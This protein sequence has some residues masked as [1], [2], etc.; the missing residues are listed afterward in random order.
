MTPY[1]LGE[2]QEQ[3]R[4]STGSFVTI[5]LCSGDGIM[6]AFAFC[7]LCFLEAVVLKVGGTIQYG[8]R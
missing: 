4:E 2:G 5:D 7:A 1:G 8:P 6:I 3:Q